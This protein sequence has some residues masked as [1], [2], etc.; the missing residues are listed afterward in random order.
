M[1]QQGLQQGLQQGYNKVLRQ[2]DIEEQIASTGLW[3]INSGSRLRHSSLLEIVEVMEE[4]R[5]VIIFATE[6]ILASLANLLGNTENLLTAPDN[7]KNFDL[8]E[9][10][11]EITIREEA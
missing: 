5:T 2:Y 3:K 8:D 4:S 7:I 11:V 9:F 10:K 1:F 6:P